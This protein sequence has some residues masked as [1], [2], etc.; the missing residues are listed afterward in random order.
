[1][2]RLLPAAVAFALF[3]VAVIPSAQAFVTLKDWNGN[4]IYWDD[5]PITWYIHP[6]GSD[7][8][9]FDDLIAALSAGM[10]AWDSQSCFTKTIVYGG[11]KT[12]DPQNGVYLKF[13]ESNWDASVGDALAYA[14]TWKGWGG[15]I[16]NGVIV[17]NG[18]AAT[19]SVSETGFFSTTADVQG[20]V[21]H[22]MGHI[23]GLDHTRYQDATMYFSGGG[24]G[25]QTL[26]QDDIN[27]LCYIYGS[28]SDGLT[29]D[30]CASNSDCL[31]GQCK[32]I[33][34]AYYCRNSCSNNSQC[35]DTFYCETSSGL[36]KPSNGYCNQQGGNIALG[37]FCYGM[38]TCQSGLCLVLPS[39]AY[40]SKECSS[41][42]QCSGMNCTS[43]YCIYPGEQELGESCTAHF[44][45]ISGTCVG[46]GNNEGVCSQ[47]CDGPLD[48]PSGL[49]C[50]SG[51]CYPGGDTPYGSDCTEDLQCQYTKC[52]SV[53]GTK[54]ICSAACTAN[55]D[56]PNSDPCVQGFCV[57][58]GQYP[59]G[60]KCTY[61]TDCLGG[62][63]V[64][65]GTKT[66]CSQVCSASLVCPDGSVC[67]S[68]NYC[69]PETGVT[70]CLSNGDC[71]SGKFCKRPGSA[72]YGLCVKSC[73]A[74]ADL[75]CS[76]GEDCAWYWDNAA[77]KVYGE[78]VAYAGGGQK[79]DEPCGIITP[80]CKP[81]LVCTS[82]SGSA[83]TCFRDCNTSNGLG[84]VEGEV[85]LSL[86]NNNDPLHGICFCE[87]ECEEPAPPPDVVEQDYGPWRPD[88]GSE[89]DLATQPDTA[90]ADSSD[91]ASAPDL[92]TGV[93]SL[94]T[95]NDAI[96]EADEGSIYT[97]D[98]SPQNAKG[99]SCSA[100]TAPSLSISQLLPLAVAL[101][102]L[103]LRR[104]R[105]PKKSS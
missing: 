43:G 101:A 40:C 3:T 13:Q 42:S 81:S 65:M 41:S 92:S 105:I 11:T 53:G 59:L 97:P 14:Q 26:A 46:I 35:G 78:C 99:G 8:V 85:C 58:K 71:G 10:N 63:C 83:L 75:G 47:T 72:A 54:K 37:D 25:M 66:F 48:C 89:D 16:T 93:D 19:W 100:S 57:P 62:Y 64:T 56:C 36:C 74:Y 98:P 5:N 61:D 103:C 27:G 32:S 88:F 55:A 20:V 91:I 6:N 34:G 39:D 18:Q 1:M 51:Y 38:E 28:F 50:A 33:G 76:Q 96:T 17:F 52:L 82:V 86:N 67:S 12:Y 70:Y 87:G 44:D 94:P 9:P 68:S 84:C 21:T 102:L 69:L 30:S 31:S 24:A 49:S 4:D 23:L 45:C 29:C 95:Q 7:N 22:E 79:S 90:S 15:V 2:R 73:N 77:A 60:M 80:L 104:G